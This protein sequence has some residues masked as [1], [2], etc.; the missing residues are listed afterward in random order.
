LRESQNKYVYFLLAIAG[1]MIGL[2]V[3]QTSGIG[4][5][6]SQ[7]VLAIAV[8]FWGISFF[9]GCRHI[10]YINS[11][12]YTNIDILKASKG[13][14]PE[15]EGKSSDHVQAAIEGMLMAFNSNAEKANNFAK[16]QFI[17]LIIGAI[18][19]LAWHIFEMYLKTLL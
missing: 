17:F 1:A 13:Q 15:L 19:Y 2:A 9:F 3:Q 8:L 10:V 5:S 7:S 4:I 11:C 6:S 12:I 16:W 18:C 14:H